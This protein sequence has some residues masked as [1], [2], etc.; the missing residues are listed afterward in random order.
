MADENRYIACYSR[1]CPFPNS[2]LKLWMDVQVCVKSGFSDLFLDG[3]SLPLLIDCDHHVV[4]LMLLPRLLLNLPLHS[5]LVVCARVE[6][7]ANPVWH[8]YSRPHLLHKITIAT[9]D[10]FQEAIVHLV[11]LSTDVA[12]ELISGQEYWF[13]IA[14]CCI[15]AAL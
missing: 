15:H 13:G 4:H 10:D 8:A 2:F 12:S 1:G 9:L 5:S 14:P 11:L 7:R 3:L 6:R